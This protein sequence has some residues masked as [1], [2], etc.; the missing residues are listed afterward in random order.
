MGPA[1]V[2]TSAP[3]TSVHGSI[4]SVPEKGC[5]GET[6]QSEM[7]RTLCVTQHV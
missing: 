2:A 4:E 7:M 5:T 6:R 1:S 3:E